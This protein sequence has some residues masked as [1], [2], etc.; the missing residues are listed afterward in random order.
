[1]QNN[2]TEIIRSIASGIIQCAIFADKPEGSNPRVTRQAKQQAEMLAS[3]FVGIIGDVTLLEI[4]EAYHS[5]GYGSHPDCGSVMPWLVACG[6]DVWFTSQG[7]G[8]GFWDREEL[9]F[10]CDGDTIDL[11]D[12]LTEACTKLRHVEPAFYRGWFYLE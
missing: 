5:H 6:H 12:R 10:D 3:Q 8:T 11:A 1:M 7:H 4:E 2:Q 9:K